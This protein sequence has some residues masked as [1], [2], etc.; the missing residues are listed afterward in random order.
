MNASYADASRLS[1]ISAQV[2]GTRIMNIA[3]SGAGYCIQ[4]L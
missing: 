2:T 3:I 4:L 1:A